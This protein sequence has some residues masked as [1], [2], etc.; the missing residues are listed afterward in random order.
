MIEYNEAIKVLEKNIEQQKKT[1]EIHILDS[2]GYIVA[3][4]VYSSISVPSFPKSAMD[5]YAVC[6]EDIINAEKDIPVKLKVAG[7]IIAGDSHVIQGKKGQA[8]RIMTGGR[9]P[10]GFDCVVKQEDTDYGRDTVNIF[11][12]LTPYSNYCKI[13]KIFKKDNWL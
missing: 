9:I 8:V 2:Y 12:S 6:S 4:D 10:D 1:E 5:G 7:K 11:T 3:E 13:E